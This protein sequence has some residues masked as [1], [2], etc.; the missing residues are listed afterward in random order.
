MPVRTR[1]GCEC[2]PDLTIVRDVLDRH[3]FDQGA[4]IAVLQ[5]TQ[6]AYGYL[7]EM[8]LE[9]IARYRHVPISQVYGVATFY[10]RFRLEPRGRSIVQVCHG[11]TCYVSGAQQVTDDIA[12]ELGVKV[13]GTTSDGEF[14]LE[15]IP[16]I[17]RCGLAPVVLVD[18]TAYGKLD[19]KT[20]SETIAS[21]R[22]AAAAAMHVEAA[23]CKPP[24]TR[25]EEVS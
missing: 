20:V 16:C 22:K 10:S 11:T 23:A 24:A 2:A 21:A 12:D 1:I 13:G 7:P 4:L 5:E 25:A 14:T 17:G 15:K 18:D 3:A 6:A 9:E 8:A 19:A